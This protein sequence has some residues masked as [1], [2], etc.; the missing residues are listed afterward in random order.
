MKKE[1]VESAHRPERLVELWPLERLKPYANNPRANDAAV[2]AV[3][4]SIREFGFLV[5]IVATPEGEILAGHTRLKAAQSLGLGEVPVLVARDL[6]EAKARAFRLADN[7]TAELAEWDLKALDAELA[8]LGD[9]DMAQFGFEPKDEPQAGETEAD[10]AP[11]VEVDEPPRSEPGALYALGEHRLVC[12]DSTDAR[13]VSRLMGGDRA[14]LLL[15]DPPYNVAYEGAAGSIANDSMAE[16]EFLAFLTRAFKAA[17]GALEPGAA[18]Y[19]FHAD[20]EGLSFRL[21]AKAAELRVRQCLVWVKNAAVM[22]RQDYQWKHEPCLYGW[23]EGAPHRWFADRKQTTV[24]CFPKPTKSAE[25]PTMKPVALLEALLH[26]SSA[27]GDLVL[28]TFG[29]S[30]S[31]LIACERMGRRA[32]LAELEPRFCDVIRRRWAE[33]AHGAGCDWAALT[34]KAGEDA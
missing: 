23:K 20:S 15:T 14:A 27:R 10:D 22:G 5:P 25:H 28:D 2:P 34:P 6:D 1:P 30:G 3:A 16:G 29:G 13:T 12:G 33:H 24:L 8:G 31:T 19:I 4:A 26:N 9:L 21:A 32:R 11:G 17:A 7:K 18:F